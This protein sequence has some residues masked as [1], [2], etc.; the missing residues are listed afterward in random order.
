MVMPP[1]KPLP[2]SA[3]TGTG[4]LRKGFGFSPRPIGGN[5]RLNKENPDRGEGAFMMKWFNG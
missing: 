5:S 1:K 3:K 4:R 2:V